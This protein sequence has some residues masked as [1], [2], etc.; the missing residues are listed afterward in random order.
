MPPGKPTGHRSWAQQTISRF[1]NER[2]LSSELKLA[3]A[4]EAVLAEQMQVLKRR[5]D[6]LFPQS[7]P[8]R[9]YL[10]RTGRSL[11]LRWRLASAGRSSHD[12]FE[13]RHDKSPGRDI[14][15]ALPTTRR[16]RYLKIAR[17]ALTL[18]AAYAVYRYRRDRLADH[19]R[20][21]DRLAT[22]FMHYQ[23]G[24]PPDDL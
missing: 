23:A 9:L 22:T 18:N 13:L 8:A 1:S 3:A 20:K 21:M 6:H 2:L 15:N 14:L 16:N 11:A 19:L 10:H 5:F 12:F 7:Q 24:I 4:A 17:E